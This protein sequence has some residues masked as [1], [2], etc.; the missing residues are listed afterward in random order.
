[1]AR[2]PSQDMRC[3]VGDAGREDAAAHGKQELL[4]FVGGAN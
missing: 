2:V 4:G 3:G 1:M